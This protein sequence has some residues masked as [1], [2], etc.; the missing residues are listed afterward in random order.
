M[1]TMQSALQNLHFLVAEAEP[2]QRRALIEA[3]GQL[4]AS[5]VT[6]VPDGP[7]ALRTLQAASRRKS[8]SPSS[9]WPWAAW[10]ASNCCAR[11]RA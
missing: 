3:L 9:T 7:T 10:T 11:S 2:V 8:T 6:D 1:D 4:G 5:R